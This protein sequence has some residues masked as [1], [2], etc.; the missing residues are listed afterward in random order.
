MTTQTVFFR[1]FSNGNSV[2]RFRE[3]IVRNFNHVTGFF[4]LQIS[5]MLH[6]RSPRVPNQGLHVFQNSKCWSRTRC[7]FICIVKI[8]CKCCASLKVFLIVCM[9]VRVVHTNKYGLLELY[10]NACRAAQFFLM[11]LCDICMFKFLFRRNFTKRAD[12]PP[13]VCFSAYACM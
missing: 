1:V 6:E 3:S 9:S 7:V 5:T 11:A 4:S 13:F 12:E 2:I 8:S 10:W